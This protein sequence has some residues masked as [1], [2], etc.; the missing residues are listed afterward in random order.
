MFKYLREN[1]KLFYWVIAATFIGGFVLMNQGTG[2]CQ[3]PSNN[4]LE[5]GIVGVVNGTK[6]PQNLYDGYYK[7]QLQQY[8]ARLGSNLRSNSV[9]ENIRT[10]L[11]EIAWQQCVQNIL[12]DQAVQEFKDDKKISV[13]DDEIVDIFRNNPPQYLQNVFRNEENQFDEDLYLTSLNNKTGINWDQAEQNIVY[14][15]E[16]MK[17]QQIIAMGVAVGDDEV[18]EEYQRRNGKAQ[19]EYMGMLFA[20]LE[21]EYTP[22]DAAVES[23]FNTHIDQYQAGAKTQCQVVKFEIKPSEA[24][25]QGILTEM[26]AIRQEILNGETTFEL[27][28]QHYSTDEGTKLNGGDLG[29]FDRK[30][31]VTPFSDAAF[32][33][34]IGEISEPI[35]TQFGYH[36]IEVLEQIKDEESGEVTKVKARHILWATTPTAET[37]DS[38]YQTALAFSDGVNA[39]NFISTAEAQ[40]LELIKLMPAVDGNA[41]NGVVISEGQDD[42]P[43]LTNSKEGSLWA[44]K[45]SPGEISRIFGNNESYY[46]LLAESNIPA[47]AADLADVRSKVAL[48]MRK[49]KNKEWAIEKLAPAVQEVQAGK[50]MAD[51]AAAAGLTYALSDT[52]TANSPIDNVGYGTEFNMLALNGTVG[53]VVSDVESLRGIFALNPLYIAAFDEEDF[54][55]NKENIMGYL[56]GRKQEEAFNTWFMD[57]MENATIDDQRHALSSR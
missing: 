22:E 44:L 15:L 45:S 18:R 9:T 2:S 38:I 23:Y 6:V 39:G 14:G 1:A 55:T 10:D 56:L 12:L 4:R 33:L 48:D 32:S 27:A 7:Q 42:I 54:N 51:A 46:V 52:F 8:E 26:Q 3:G 29:S 41:G 50:S 47:G 16:R 25:L 40:S 31:M 34:P 53:N 57:R 36:L 24:D 30:A 49:E 21:N 28:V 35:L 19:A 5:Q 20:D 11:H 43:G 17:L 37:R 13:T